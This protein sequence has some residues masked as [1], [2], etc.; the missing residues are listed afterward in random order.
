VAVA[1]SPEPVAD[2]VDPLT[3]WLDDVLDD[4]ISQLGPRSAAAC[5]RMHAY[6]ADREDYGHHIERYVDGG[7][8][9]YPNGRDECE[10]GNYAREMPGWDVEA[11]SSGL[12]GRQH[13][14]K[15]ITPTGHGYL[16][17]AP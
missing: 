5:A 13:T 16:S 14:I 4:P 6:D 10:R 7:L 3:E 1:L 8:T 11:V 2:P 15:I 9:I 17:R 12:D